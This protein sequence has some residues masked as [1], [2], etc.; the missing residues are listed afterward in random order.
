MKNLILKHLNCI[1]LSYKKWH[2]SINILKLEDN[3]VNQFHLLILILLELHSILQK[4]IILKMKITY[5]EIP[6]LFN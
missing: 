1:N 5:S 4:K 2:S 3:L 6:T